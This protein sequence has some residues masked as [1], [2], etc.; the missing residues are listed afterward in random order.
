MFTLLCVD[1]ALNSSFDYD[2]LGISRADFLLVILG[3]QVVVEIS[4]FLA[5]FLAM[6]ETF[7]FRVG[8]L[9]FLIKKFRFVLILNPVYLSFTIAAGI[10]RV[11][12]LSTGGTVV[13]LWKNST[14]VGLSITQKL[15]MTISS[16]NDM[17]YLCFYLKALNLF[18]SVAVV[19][20]VSNMRATMKLGSSMYF[21]RSLWVSLVKEV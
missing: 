20:Y 13:D 6:A 1:L 7:L 4:V 16:R 19:Y 10:Y 9:G 21:D 17:I 18:L 2:T 14:F 5:L 8:L 12:I 3:L 15:G 11:H